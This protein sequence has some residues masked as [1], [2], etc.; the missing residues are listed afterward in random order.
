MLK[1]YFA[2]PIAEADLLPFY[3]CEAVQYMHTQG[4]KK[5]LYTFK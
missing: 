4:G 5:I 3:Y 1:N 2:V